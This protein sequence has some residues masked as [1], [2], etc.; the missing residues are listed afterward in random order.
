MKANST[1][2][3]GLVATI[4]AVACLASVLTMGGAAKTDNTS[5]L[6]APINASSSGNTLQVS[7]KAGQRIAVKRYFLAAGGAVTATWKSSG[8]TA[9]SGPLTLAAAGAGVIDAD[10]DALFATANGEG[11][12]LNLSGAVA[13]GGYLVFWYE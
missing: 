11:L 8:G 5:K 10:D 9:L 7:G 6:Y 4:L 2:R 1:L 12:T 3:R 13:V